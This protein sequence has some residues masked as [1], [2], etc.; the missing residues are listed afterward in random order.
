MVGDGES[1]VSHCWSGWLQ[2]S[3]EEARMTHV[4]LHE[5]QRNQHELRVNLIYIWM[6]GCIQEE[7]VDRGSY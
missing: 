1:Q 4:I 3:K 7:G 2:I 6:D 5:S